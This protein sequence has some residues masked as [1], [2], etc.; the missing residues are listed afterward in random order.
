MIFVKN[1]SSQA[2]MKLFLLVIQFQSSYQILGRFN[3]LRIG[4]PHANGLWKFKTIRNVI[5][6]EVKNSILRESKIE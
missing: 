3:R 6:L 1:F 5:L 4:K 2:F